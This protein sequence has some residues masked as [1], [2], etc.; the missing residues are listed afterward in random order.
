MIFKPFLRVFALIPFSI[1]LAISF[2]IL[3]VLTN[4]KNK[5]IKIFGYLVI[6]II[7]VSASIIGYTVIFS[8]SIQCPNMFMHRGM[9]EK[10]KG[11]I[12]GSGML[13]KSR[14][15]LSE[16]QTPLC[17]DGRKVK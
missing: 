5:L 1:L 7:W 14:G 15:E 8:P 13:E 17:P 11:M 16:S 3:V 12:K 4:V 9:L 2:F 6:L 10:G